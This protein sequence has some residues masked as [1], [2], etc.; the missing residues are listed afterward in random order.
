MKCFPVAALGAAII[1]LG[2]GFGARADESFPLLKAGDQT[3]T[4]VTVTQ[5]TATDIYFTCKGGMM[6]VK[7]KKLDPSLQQH[8]HYNPAKAAEV[9]QK[10]ARG[11]AQYR[12]AAV[13]QPAPSAPNQ[14]RERTTSPQ[15][16]KAL[17]RTDLPGALAQAKSENKLVLIDFTGSDWC[18]WCMKFDRDILSTGQFGSYAAAK[19]ILVKIDF[20]QHTRQDAALKQANKELAQ[21]FNVHGYPTFVLVDASGNELGRQVGYLNGGPPVFIAKLESFGG[22]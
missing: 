12:V 18:G 16:Q 10:Q 17:W 14:T 8:F 5:V 22:S 21:R 1:V 4:N 6:N 15:P 20:P 11:G 3:Y 2:P 9:E 7:L 19:L 13:H